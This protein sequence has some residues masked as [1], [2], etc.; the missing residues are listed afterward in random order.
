MLLF[1]T[2]GPVVL[3]CLLAAAACGGGGEGVE[4]MGRDTLRRMLLTQ[5]ELGPA[6]ESFA[7]N[8]AASGYVTSNFAAGD[9]CERSPASGS[10]LLETYDQQ[11]ESDENLESES[12]VFIL[13]E[14]VAGYSDF[15]AASQALDAMLANPVDHLTLSG[16]PDIDMAE[17]EEFAPEGLEGEAGGVEQEVEAG[18]DRFRVTAVGFVRGRMLGKIV[19]A[20]FG[21]GRQQDEASELAVR[22]AERIDAVLSGAVPETPRGSLTPTPS[23]QTPGA[24]ATRRPSAS[25]GA[26]G[27]GS[28]TA[29]PAPGAPRINSVG[30]TPAEARPGEKIVCTPSISGS[31]TG[32]TWSAPGGSPSFAGTNTFETSFATTGQKVITLQACR[33]GACAASQQ[34]II[35][36]EPAAPV[37][38][39]LGCSPASV[40]TGGQVNCNPTVQGTVTSWQWTA[41]D[42]SPASGSGQTF[43]ATFSSAGSKTISLT[44]C[45]EDDCTTASRAIDVNA[46]L[47]VLQVTSG[48]LSAGETVT[49]T[50]SVQAP[51]AGLGDYDIDLSYDPQ[52]L[53]PQGCSDHFGGTCDIFAFDNTVSTSGHAGSSGNLA[54]ASVTFGVA[55]FTCCHSNLTLSAFSLRDLNGNPITAIQYLHGTITVVP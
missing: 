21:G 54:V 47:Y 10:D 9:R 34:V 8:S 38:D 7:L 55:G 49:V 18:G 32:Q 50:I 43:S 36:S 12:G 19:I 4:A 29:T 39:S 45:N 46:P 17:A 30:C 48:Q 35:V 51:S 1:Q 15:Q 16:C 13:V 24:T 37:I 14:G 31:V 53:S 33:A 28:P 41:Q 3:A 27:S 5:A 2:S 22:L 42:G 11:F 40:N 26:S 6:Y 23:G 20:H 25:P 44:A 52:V